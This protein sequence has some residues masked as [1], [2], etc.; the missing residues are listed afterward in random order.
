MLESLF[1]GLAP[2]DCNH[3]GKQPSARDSRRQSVGSRGMKNVQRRHVVND[4]ARWERAQDIFADQ[5]F[6]TYR[7]VRK[8]PPLIAIQEIDNI[9]IEERKVEEAARNEPFKSLANECNSRIVSLQVLK[10]VAHEK[11][12]RTLTSHLQFVKV[13]FH[14]ARVRRMSNI[15]VTIHQQAALREVDRDHCKTRPKQKSSVWTR[16]A[17]KLDDRLVS[18]PCRQAVEKTPDPIDLCW[19]LGVLKVAGSLPVPCANLSDCAKSLGV[20]ILDDVAVDFECG[21]ARTSEH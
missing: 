13:S 7:A 15:D 1:I 19:K 21:A 9:E 3:A 18:N 11:K 8:S 5:P 14:E 17:P 6:I 10:K 4:N 16:T 12:I 20:R 2:R